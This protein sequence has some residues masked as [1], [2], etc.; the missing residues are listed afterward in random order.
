[1]AA[2]ESALLIYDFAFF[3]LHYKKSH[4]DVRKENKKVIDFHLRF[5]AEIVG[6]TDKD[7]LFV[8]GLD[9]YLEVRKRYSRFLR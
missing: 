8:Y 7:L 1:M 6:E 3:S 4:F 9:T 5:G 2:I